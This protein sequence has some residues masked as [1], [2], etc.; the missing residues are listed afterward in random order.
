M[1]IAILAAWRIENYNGDYYIPYVH[2]SY[3]EYV[4]SK[5]ERVYLISPHFKSQS[6]QNQF[7]HIEFTNIEYCKI[8]PF[9]SYVSAVTKFY[10]YYSAIKSVTDKVDS[11]YCRVPDP[12]SW[13]PCLLSSNRVVMHFVGDTIDA[14]MRNSNW[15]IVKRLIMILFYI[16]EFILTLLSAKF[17]TVYTNGHHISSKLKKLGINATA[18]VSSTV[19]ECD[20]KMPT[21]QLSRNRIN[22]IYVGY[23]RYAK[24]LNTLLE[25]LSK[26]EK[27]SVDYSFNIV[28][29]GEMY[30]EINHF[31]Q[32]NHLQKKVLLHGHIDDRVY[33]NNL[34]QESDLFFFPS[35]SEG[36][37]RVIIEAIAQGVPVLSTP[38]GSVPKVFEEGID[39]RLFDFNDSDSALDV[40]K[41]F[42]NDS[43]S[44]IDLRNKAFFKVKSNYTIET[45][46]SKI[47]NNEA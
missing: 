27:E 30:E 4:S 40:I 5:Y 35:L 2:Y 31:V 25:L 39:I 22:L 26:L 36:S 8:S 20:L 3:L 24:G 47:F 23:L 6:I 37:P 28:G 12:F 14:T 34:L 15:S 33:L 18:V 13:M 46:L 7:K 32:I 17:S 11:F 38:V 1:N 45:F 44:F 21:R 43:S 41:D 19:K 10:E 29:D 42:V 16:P 9:D